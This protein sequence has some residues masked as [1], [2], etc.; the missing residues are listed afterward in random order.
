MITD[1]NLEREIFDPERMLSAFTRHLSKRFARVAEIDQNE[2]A[3]KYDL[4]GVQ[5]Y[6]NALDELAANYPAI[7]WRNELKRWLGESMILFRNDFNRQVIRQLRD[8]QK[9]RNIAITSAFPDESFRIIIDH[10][11]GITL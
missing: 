1:V 7:D 9:Q 8:M 4:G 6:V 10:A 5:A 2:L 3:E 11:G